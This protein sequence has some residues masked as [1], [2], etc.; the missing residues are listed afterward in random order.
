MIEKPVGIDYELQEMQKM[1]IASLWPDIST[2]KKQFNH[3]VFSNIRDGEKVPEIYVKNGEYQEVLFDDRLSALSWF[4]VSDTAETYDRTC[5]NQV[6]GLF[7]LVNLNNLYPTMAHRAVEEAHLAVQKIIMKRPTSFR[8][9]SLIT[10]ESAYGDYDTSKL[11]FPNMQPWHVFKFV[12]T[13][14]YELNCQF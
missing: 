8:I 14:N 1:F 7:F 3:R 12:C 13:V 10:G 6:V 2:A 4:D 9:T 11:R 5:Y